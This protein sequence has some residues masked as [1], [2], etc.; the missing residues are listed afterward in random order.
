M[1]SN[2]RLDRLL[3]ALAVFCLPALSQE[4]FVLRSD[5]AQATV[6]VAVLPFEGAEK[7]PEFKELA[8]P[9]AVVRADLDFSGRTKIVQPPSNSWDSAFFVQKN[10]AAVVTGIVKA[11]ASAGEVEI[12]FQ[13][14]DAISRDK[15]AEK[16]YTG[17]KKDLRRLSHR[18]SDDAIFQLFGERG[19]ASTRIAYVRGKDGRKEIW[20]MDYDGFGSQ[21]W[22]KNGNLNLSPVW[23]RDGALVWSSYL[24][25]NG[26]H[27]LRQVIGQKPTR[28]LPNTPGMQIS[29]AA[30]P[31][32]GEIA[33]A[34][35]LDGQTEIFRS[36]PN[37]KP[38]RLTFSPALEVSP[39]WSPNGYEI[40]FTSDR[41]GAPQVYAM[42]REGSNLRRITWVGG[43]N[44]QAA[45]SPMGDRIAFARQAGDFQILTISPDGS[46]EKWL[47]VGEQPKWSPDGRHIVFIR[48]SGQR[49]DL[50]VCSADGSAP[51]QLTFHGDATQPAWSR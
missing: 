7:V 17:K 46:D 23:D 40:A 8:S 34:V 25:G 10:V 29:A 19:I 3:P 44:D 20:T 47:G 11:G 5:A 26:A 15:L 35:S 31:I 41:T 48:R 24:G 38:V 50:W 42:D 22:T 4:D 16:T 51:R 39:T 21:A 12:R 36:Q 6:N 43:Y 1:F 28:F 18:F 45:W 14:L 32:D 2:M 27:L 30:S 33:V 37:G 13:L 9:D 49:S